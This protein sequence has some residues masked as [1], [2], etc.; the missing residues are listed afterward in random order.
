MNGRNIS[1]MVEFANGRDVLQNVQIFL[2]TVGKYYERLI[3]VING[4]G[5]YD[6]RSIF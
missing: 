5:F 2:W 3:F 6:Q 1:W 4:P